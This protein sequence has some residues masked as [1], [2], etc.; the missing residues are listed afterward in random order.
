MNNKLNLYKI[1][2]QQTVKPPQMEELLSQYA[3]IKRKNLFQ[4]IVLNILMVF[5]IAFI[6]FI[7]LYFEPKLI[8]TKIGIVLTL[9]GISVYLYVYNQLIPYLIKIDENQSNSAFL[10]TVIKL[11]E[12]Q[13][14]LQ[15]TILQIYF[16]MLTVGLCLYLY[17]YVS[18]L[19]FA[20]AI[21]AYV[22]IL[23]WISF[24]WFYLRPRIVA[25]ERNKLD[26]IIEKF[27]DIRRQQKNGMGD[28]N[29]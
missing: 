17:E 23:V 11:K 1:W 29:I 28:G 19:P 6:I 14:F 22:T 13:R 7:W 9:F 2:S 21:F 10:K 8:T 26:G 12:Q 4:L 27:E 24:N 18:L 16:S 5:T 25:K 20:W 3:K 15:T